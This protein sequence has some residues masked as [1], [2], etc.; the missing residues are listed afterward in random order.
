MA[1]FMAVAVSACT[2]LPKP[3]SHKKMNAGN[4]LLNLRDS[5][6]IRVV[7]DAAVPKDISQPLAA[8]MVKTLQKSNILATTDE[9][10]TG[11]LFLI[12]RV[13]VNRKSLESL[14]SAVFSW[15]LID[16]EDRKIA[17]FDLNVEGDQPGWLTGDPELFSVIAED[18]GHQIAS[19]LRQRN[20]QLANLKRPKL[21]MADQ[22]ASQPAT[23][24][25]LNPAFFLSEII[26]APGDGNAALFTALG[27][28]F[29]R[30]GSEVVAKR[31]EV[32]FLVKGFVSVSPPFKGKNDVAI[33]WLVTTPGGKELGKVTQ[34]NKVPAGY[35]DRTWGDIAYAVAE[36]ARVGILNV[37]DTAIQTPAVENEGKIPRT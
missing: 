18:A 14:E 10:F 15:T 31:D 35:L 7:F 11:N 24:P 23:Q 26:G 21:D 5:G 16:R 36:G 28:V 34:N 19:V 8:T 32:A 1:F 22:P 17:Y 20:E 4:P 2:E 9:D 29:R 6:G 25:P 12:G 3:F 27:N 37:L 30:S 13:S 33:T